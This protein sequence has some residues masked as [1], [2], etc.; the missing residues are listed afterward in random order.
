MHELETLFRPAS[1]AIIGAS[2]DPAK[3]GGRPLHN[4]LRYGYA[5]RIHPV[6][7]NADE[8]QGLKAYR[9]V[10]DIPGPVDQAVIV[11]P[12]PAVE[13]ALA[14]CAAKGIRI[15]QVLSSGFAEIG[16]DG[17]VLQQR[18]VDLARRE[19]V[20]ITGPNALGSISAPDNFFATFTGLLATVRPTAGR[21]AFATQS[22]AFGSHAY[23][24]ATLRGLGMSR[25]VATGNEADIDVAACIDYLAED[26]GTDVICAAIEGCRDG[27]RLRRALLKAAAARKPVAVMKVGSTEAGA[28]AAATHT[29][30]LAGED[31]VFDAVLR[32]CGAFRPASIEAMVDFAYLR[33]VAPAPPN[34]EVGIVTISGGIGVLMA[35]ACIASGLQVPR[36]APGVRATVREI[37]PVASG[38]NP[39]DATAQVAG[40]LQAFEGIVGTLLRDT[41]VGT[42]LLYLAHVGR[43]PA[44]FGAIEAALGRL[45]ARHPDRLIVLGMTHTEEVRRRLDA[46][47]V[48]V[49]EDP[50]R[51]V[52]AV[53]AAL[54]SRRLQ[55][56]AEALPPAV[57][58]RPI[59]GAAS[60]EAAAKALLAG[61]GIPVLPERICAT[62]EEA[63]RAAADLGFPVAAKILSDDIPHKTEV[64]GVL[65]DLGDAETVRAG[66]AELLRRARAAA[67]GARIDGVLVAPMVRGGAETIL[68]VQRDPVFG[69]MV[70]FGMG[71]VAV[72]LFRDVAF[73]SAPLSAARAE[74][75]VAS[76]RGA[77]LL[78]G[79][80]GGPP[81][82]RGALV[83][84]LRRLSEF[85]AAQGEIEGVEVNPFLVRAEG[86]VALDAL[87]AFRARGDAA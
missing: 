1:V 42:V 28:A 10:A 64:G 53:A 52:Q 70:M 29:G 30:S 75:L 11:V 81:L 35:D 73:A 38:E 2:S 27:D 59:A 3:L 19:G 9:S 26:P 79:W 39:I 61:A 74:R 76:V 71:G 66:F 80:R 17:A 23:A 18:L 56:E 86:A 58:G 13:G 8:V 87:V 84:A 31:R 72:E 25:A 82:D 69:P 34:A 12:A 49:F 40:R 51:A 21:I 14:A 48:P 4:L 24:V 43:D 45:R 57:P 85:A 50:T 37:L 65:L 22:G 46:I 7:S 60:N 44:R 6:N 16:G 20:R 32:E 36:L 41:A 54:A 63:A 15:V 55:D 78:D 62:A 47:G 67:P 77:R 33:S 68:G 5:G 83:G